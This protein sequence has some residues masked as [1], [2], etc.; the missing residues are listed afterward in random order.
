MPMTY[1]K[2]DLPA[3]VAPLHVDDRKGMELPDRLMLFHRMAMRYIN[4]EV[5]APE[6][7]ES[8]TGQQ[9]GVLGEL[10]WGPLAMNRIA[11]L[12]GVTP[13]AATALVARLVERDLVERAVVPHNRRMILVSLTAEGERVRAD[14]YDR[15]RARYVLLLDALSPE[16]RREYDDI[17]Q[18]LQRAL[19]EQGHQR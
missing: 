17:L 4:P 14:A 3:T 16:Q 18:T 13:A 12:R 15:V 10:R 8:L 1:A 6:G 5:H 19:R 7:Y 9:L 2:T 11:E